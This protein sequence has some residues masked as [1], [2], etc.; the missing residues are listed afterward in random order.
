MRVRNEDKGKRRW[1]K[2]ATQKRGR[3]SVFFVCV[4]CNI[5]LYLLIFRLYSYLNYPV[6]T[7]YTLC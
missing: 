5:E 7:N 4:C 6:N 2:N 1:K 3:K